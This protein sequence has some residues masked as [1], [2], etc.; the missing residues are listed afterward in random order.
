MKL[1][2]LSIESSKQLWFSEFIELYQKKISHY[3]P[4][5]IVRLRSKDRARDA[6]D[7]KIAE[8]GEQLLG[9]I[10]PSDFVV[11]CDERGQSLDTKSFSKKMISALESGK[12]RLVFVIGGAY[13]TSDQVK[14]RAD[15]K[16]SLSPMVLN[17]FVAQ[18]VALE[19]LYRALTIWKGVPYHNE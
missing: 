8:E 15:L 4:L 11:L 1:V 9:Q 12:K 5:Q 2:L 13:G 7:R 19:Q 6:Q 17:H 18:V 16:W 3:V 10:D 14:A